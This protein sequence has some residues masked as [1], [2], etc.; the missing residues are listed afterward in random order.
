MKKTF[1]IIVA[2]LAGGLLVCSCGYGGQGVDG[3][4]DGQD[5]GGGDQQSNECAQ[6]A[7]IRMLAI[8]PICASYKD[9]CCFCKCWFDNRKTFNVNEY[10]QNETCVCELQANPPTC[11]GEV[12]TDAQQCLADQ[13]TCGQQAVDMVTDAE[14]GMCTLTPL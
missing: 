7:E 11:E 5:G 6:A 14:E 3:G 4:M 10:F 1:A 12:L 13:V 2:L 8:D 9:T